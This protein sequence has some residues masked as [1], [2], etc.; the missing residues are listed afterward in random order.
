MAKTTKKGTA[1]TDS[2]TKSGVSASAGKAGS[3]PVTKAP[4]AERSVK[5]AAAKK[6]P[7][8]KAVANKDPVTKKVVAK[9]APSKKA[10]AQKKTGAKAD[11]TVSA[12]ERHELI[13]QAAYLR[14]EA[15][16]FLSNAADDWLAAEMEVDARLDTAGIKVT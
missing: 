4:A 15:Q 9:K 3:G 1:K 6:R 2:K 7:A 12:Q 8:K 5:P 14:S 13:A 11:R 10:A 16:G